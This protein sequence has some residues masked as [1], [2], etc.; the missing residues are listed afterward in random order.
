MCLDWYC[1]LT[2][3][4]GLLW[5][6]F[7]YTRP[8]TVAWLVVQ[9]LTLVFVNKILIHTLVGICCNL[10]NVP[11]CLRNAAWRH[12]E[13]FCRTGRSIFNSPPAPPGARSPSWPT[14]MCSYLA[15]PQTRTTPTGLV[16]QVFTAQ[17][18]LHQAHW[19][20][21]TAHYTL[22]NKCWTFHTLRYLLHTAYCTIHTLYR[23][24]W[25]L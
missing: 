20:L 6:G 14:T 17:W 5:Y 13:T 12:L 3:I 16:L 11:F 22:H 8:I 10:G 21:Y 2:H 9:C 4:W 7:P 25:E 23:N 24:D 1:L 19:T 18:K 15:W